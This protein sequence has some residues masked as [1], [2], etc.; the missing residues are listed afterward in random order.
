MAGPELE[1]GDGRVSFKVAHIPKQ[2]LVH[3][4][5]H[6]ICYVWHLVGKM[7]FPN[8]NNDAILGFQSRMYPEAEAPGL[9]A[10]L[11]GAWSKCLFNGRCSL[12]PCP[13]P[14]SQPVPPRTKIVGKNNFLARWPALVLTLRIA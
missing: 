4:G 10:Y 6:I 5:N 14:S 13:V 3:L 11:H 8:D 7:G 12:D 1:S 9:N 2:C